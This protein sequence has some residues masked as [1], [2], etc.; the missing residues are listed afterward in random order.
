MDA[1]GLHYR[2]AVSFVC[3][4]L[5]GPQL[6]AEFGKKLKLRECINTW[7]DEDNKPTWGQL[8]CSGF[9]ILDGQR[10]VVC[11][12]SPAYLDEKERAFHYVDTFLKSLI[13]AEATWA[14]RCGPSIRPTPTR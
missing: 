12:K 5:D 2:D 14:A 4:C 7:V 13:D 10:T 3:V 1:W 8:G 9:I 11:P 6:A